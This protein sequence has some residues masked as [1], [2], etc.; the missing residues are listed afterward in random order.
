MKP[1]D[2]AELLLLAALWGASF[3]FLRMGAGEFGPATLAGLRVAGAALVLLPLLYWNAAGLAALRV[4]WK[5]IA[6]VGLT[7]SALPFLAF[8]YAA[9]TIP[10]GLASIFNAA[11]PLFGAAIAWGWL[12]ERPGPM[13]L[14]GLAIGFAGVAGLAIVKARHGASGA[15]DAAA[16]ATGLAIAACIAATLSYGFAANYTRRRLAG[17][18]PLAVAAGSQ[19]TAALWLALPMLWWWPAQPPSPTA[20]GALALLA[21]VCTGF[22]YLLYFRLIAHVGA[23]NAIAVTFLIPGFAVGWGALVLGERITTE[24]VIGCAVILAGTA[25]A[26]GLVGSDLRRARA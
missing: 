15:G 4:H 2:L 5:P 17:V 3:L 8:G 14:L 18:P 13:R 22:A 7:N 19:A 25:L 9:L 11:A 26:T 6:V 1:R 12:G 23:G 10:A 16:L 24:M 21:V 20:W